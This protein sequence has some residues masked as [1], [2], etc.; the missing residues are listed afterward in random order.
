MQQDIQPN[1]PKRRIIMLK[2]TLPLIGTLCLTFGSVGLFGGT[3]SASDYCPPKT[4]CQPKVCYQTVTVCETRV[5][6]YTVCE[7]RYDE[8]GHCYQVTVTRYR[9][10]QVQVTRQVPVACY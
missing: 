8:C 2:R 10:V 1:S 9:T 6:P 3:A 5:V 4:Y 7:T